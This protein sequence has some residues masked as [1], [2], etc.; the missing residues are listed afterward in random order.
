MRA[1]GGINKM[2]EKAQIRSSM[3]YSL[4]DSSDGFYIN[5]VEK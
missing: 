2:A 1:E 3:V 4:I 5:K